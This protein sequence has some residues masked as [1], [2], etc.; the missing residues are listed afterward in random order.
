MERP[1]VTVEIDNS[2]VAA[3]QHHL[4]SKTV[5]LKGLLKE[6]HNLFLKQV[7]QRR[8]Q[9]HVSEEL[10]RHNLF[11]NEKQQVV[12]QIVATL[13]NGGP[14]TPYLSEKS[15]QLQHFDSS[16]AHFGV[17]HFHLGE[18]TQ[19]SGVRAGQVKG[20]KSLLFVRITES[21]A[22]LLDILN[23]DMKRG[24]LNMHLL[25]VMYRNWP[26]SIEP[27]RLKGAIGVA[28]KYSDEEAAELLEND[29]NVIVE[30]GEEQVYMLPG[31]GTTTAGT[32]LLMERRVDHTVRE[33]RRIACM[34]EHNPNA[35]SALIKQL[36]GVGHNIIRLKGRVRA[37]LL[38]IYD[39]TSGC[40]FTT[41]REDLVVSMPDEF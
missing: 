20:T 19:H 7:S 40:V 17:H 3:L 13:E 15:E 5:D 37:G 21:D 39:S 24:F 23:H 36:T 9:V 28:V 25:R 38:D 22:Y 18:K 14:L 1:V 4:G 8:R 27:F 30:L 34:V 33:F 2:L 32:P 41:E 6:F 31:M 29:V 16:L 12:E 35:V 11:K 10:T 26:E